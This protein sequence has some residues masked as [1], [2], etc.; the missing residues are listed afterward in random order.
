[1]GVSYPTRK[2]SI[3]IWADQW[4]APHK[5]V[6][7]WQ[8]NWPIDHS[9]TTAV[10]EIALL[11][12]AQTNLS[13]R[14]WMENSGQHEILVFFAMAA[15]ISLAYERKY[16]VQCAMSMIINYQIIEN[17]CAAGACGVPRTTVCQCLMQIG[18]LKVLRI[19]SFADMI[20]DLSSNGLRI[21]I[22]N[23]NQKINKILL[24]IQSDEVTRSLCCCC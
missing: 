10:A 24:L 23:K 8:Q 14:L 18:W 19:R 12:S 6:S 17:L 13:T 4:R 11:H 15:A 1:M 2:F 7:M 21:L 5:M 9:I 20:A 3:K 16:D 22:C